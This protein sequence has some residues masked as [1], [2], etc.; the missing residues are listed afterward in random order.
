MPLG[1]FRTPRIADANFSASPVEAD[2]SWGWMMNEGV[3]GYDGYGYLLGHAWFWDTTATD[4]EVEITLKGLT[5]GKNYLVQ[6]FSH[7]RSVP[8]MRFSVEGSDGHPI[9]TSTHV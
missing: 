9:G 6:L 4:V 2:A 5:P 8:D 1:K 7:N 3:P